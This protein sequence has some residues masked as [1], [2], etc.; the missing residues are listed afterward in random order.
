MTRPLAIIPS[1]FFWTSNVFANTPLH[2][3][4]L[5]EVT[6]VVVE[7]GKEEGADELMKRVTFPIVK[8]Q[9]ETVVPAKVRGPS[10]MHCEVSDTQQP[11]T[12]RNC[13]N[14]PFKRGQKIKGVAGKSLG[15]G[16]LCIQEVNLQ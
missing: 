11:Y 16:R 4:E 10:T 9:A 1:I 12:F 5:C 14:F 6:G 7:V 15:A 3:G 13:D 8:I 2:L